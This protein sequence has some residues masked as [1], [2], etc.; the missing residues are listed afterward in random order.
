MAVRRLLPVLALLILAG[1]P[2]AA[3]EDAAALRPCLREDLLGLWQV[4]RFGFASGATVDRADPAYQPHQRY[5]FHAD[6]TMA[7]A[8]T[9]TA[10]TDAAERAL[11]R[12][13]A[14][15]RWA[16]E[17]DGRLRRERGG[18]ME[19][20]TSEC[21]VVTQP[22]R[23]SRSPI[24][25]LPGDVVLTDQDETARPIARRLLRRLRRDE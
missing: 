13:P 10:P 16:L 9:A 7:Y 17:P 24:L 5:V 1:P 3:Q 18:A 8:A 25:A 22:L 21:R 4:I 20:E 12:A 2:A 19:A 6:A 23:D 15:V 11:V 14:P